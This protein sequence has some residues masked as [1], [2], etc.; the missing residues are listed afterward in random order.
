MKEID[1]NYSNLATFDVLSAFV[2]D[3]IFVT[4]GTRGLAPSSFKVWLISVA[5]VD[6]YQND[7]R[8]IMFLGSRFSICLV[9]FTITLSRGGPLIHNLK[10]IAS[11]FAFPP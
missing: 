4:V 9:T 7:S 11:H 3:R 5:R 2:S 10:L 6:D 8:N 1:A